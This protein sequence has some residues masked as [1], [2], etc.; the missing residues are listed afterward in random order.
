MRTTIIDYI[1]KAGEC[2]DVGSL[3]IKHNFETDEELVQ[4]VKENWFNLENIENVEEIII[5]SDTDGDF[6]LSLKVVE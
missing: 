1:E 6:Q 3:E 2:V 4:A 5:D